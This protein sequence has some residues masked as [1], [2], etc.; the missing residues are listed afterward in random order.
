MTAEEFGELVSY[1][2]RNIEHDLDNYAMR[3]IEERS[4]LP[5]QLE[6]AINDRAEEWCEDNDI[7]EDEYYDEHDAEEVF[8]HENYEFDS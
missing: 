4:G 8:F 1:V 3:L 2:S 7:D 5:Y 6:E